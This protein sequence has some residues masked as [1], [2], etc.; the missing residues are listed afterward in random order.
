MAKA[1]TPQKT[2][3]VVSK[4]K[5][6]APATTNTVQTTTVQTTTS[7]ASSGTINQGLQVF[8]LHDLQLYAKEGVYATTAS[9]DFHLFYVG[10]DNVHE[11]LKY[12]LSRVTV[13][14]YLN[15]FGYDDDELNAII[16]EKAVDPHITVMITYYSLLHS[17]QS[18][19]LIWARWNPVHALQVS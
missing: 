16:M 13:S 9:K 6:T 8:N 1:K 11:I 17:T 3:Q 4:K 19:P 10:R 2:R 15:M 5:S 7:N 18:R 14:L 12:V